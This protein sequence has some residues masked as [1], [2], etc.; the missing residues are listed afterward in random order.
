MYEYYL[1]CFLNFWI[2]YRPVEKTRLLF[3]NSCG[4]R[5]NTVTYVVINVSLSVCVVIKDRVGTEN[6]KWR[7][8]LKSRWGQ[9]RVLSVTPYTH[10]RPKRVAV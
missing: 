3:K 2:Q 4:S 6:V 7:K 8:K 1:H 5:N 10:E 9:M